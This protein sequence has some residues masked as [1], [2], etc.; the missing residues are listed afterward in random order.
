MQ[1]ESYPDRE[2]DGVRYGMKGESFEP[3]LDLPSR[4]GRVFTLAAGRGT[5]PAR[6]GAGWRRRRPG[7]V[8]NAGRA[9]PRYFFFVTPRPESARGA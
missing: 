3:Y 9:G 2:H 8:R 7:A 6:D 5:P 4:V 1:W